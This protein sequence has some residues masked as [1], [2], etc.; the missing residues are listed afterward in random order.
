M[1]GKYNLHCWHRVVSATLLLAGTFLLSI[2]LTTIE[3]RLLGNV[4]ENSKEKAIDTGIN[5]NSNSNNDHIRNNIYQSFSWMNTTGVTLSH[6]QGDPT[7]CT[8]VIYTGN[9]RNPFKSTTVI[10]D[11]NENDEQ[12]DEGATIVR[13]GWKSLAHIV[14]TSPILKQDTCFAF[15]LVPSPWIDHRG[16]EIHPVWGRLPATALVMKAF[17]K[18]DFFL[19]MDSDALLAFPD[20][21]PTTMYKELAFDGYGENATFQQLNPGLIVNKPFTG[22][23][24]GQCEKFGLGHGCFNSGVLLWH[25]STKAEHILKSWWSSRNSRESQNIFDPINGDSFNGWEGNDAKRIGDKMGEQNRL[26]YIYATDP[27][28]RSAVW[29]VP[30]KRSVEFNSESCPSDLKGYTPC[31]Q[32]DFIY[33]AKWDTTDPSCYVNHYADEKIQ[34]LEH[35]KMMMKYGNLLRG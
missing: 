14:R 1:V 5:S 33:K 31:L 25:R 17:P 35:A 10:D 7:T 3:N 19:Y 12:D 30:R 26:M 27:D 16:N 34:V 15:F 6:I 18:A 21:T 8:D 32:S 24:C 11:E 4:V 23:L 20:I 28:V 29:P 13:N 22:W 2:D 9:S